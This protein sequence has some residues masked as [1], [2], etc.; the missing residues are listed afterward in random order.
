M[1]KASLM[2]RILQPGGVSML[3]QPIV[4]ISR[5]Q[6]SIYAVE[7][8]A[9]GPKATN[10]EAAPLLFEYARR[11]HAENELDRVCVAKALRHATLL[12]RDMKF[13]INV[14]ASTLGRDFE[15]ASYLQECANRLELRLNRVT[16]EIV[17]HLPYWDETNFLHTLGD[18]R[19]LGV[20]IALDDFGMGYSNYRMMLEAKPDYF[21]ID[22][23][24]VDGCHA[25]AERCFVLESIADLAGRFGAA[26]V[27][28][29]VSSQQDLNALRK[30]GFR[31]A[32][33]YLFA[34]PMTASDL[35]GSPLH[36]KPLWAYPESDFALV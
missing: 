10:L 17:E 18:L 25:D 15:F 5:L 8:L 31:L 14:H 29:G 16:I 6:P 36:D 9:R 23:Y 24:L 35:L 11:K 21:K 13:S 7:C 1:S 2:E 34:R 19:T 30:M 32:Q 27:A 20:K 26:V 12:P 28:E 22:R 4:D 33:G 3:F